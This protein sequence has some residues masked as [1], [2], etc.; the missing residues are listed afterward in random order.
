MKVL[1][2][3]RA[4]ELLSYDPGTGIV[5]WRVNRKGGARAGS[6]AG[7]TMF[8]GYRKIGIDGR[9]YLTH[10]IAWLL[11]T[12]C[13]PA[14]EIDHIN[15]NRTDNRLA[16]LRQATRAE[17][18]Q[19]NAIRST[20]TSGFA[21]VTWNKVWKKWQAQITTNR[22][23]RIVGYFDDPESASEAYIAAKREMHKFA[24]SVRGSQC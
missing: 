20:N 8:V 12:G 7:T 18:S 6:E 4:C 14:F 19:N 9:E 1:T 22:R 2:Y 13:W 17:N 21:G 10:R 16:N 11:A 3:Q 15:G 5:L 23:L 24:P